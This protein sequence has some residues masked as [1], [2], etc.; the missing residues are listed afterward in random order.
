MCYYYP[1]NIIKQSRVPYYFMVENQGSS[2]F[3]DKL[4]PGLLNKHYKETLKTSAMR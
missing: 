1:L 2:T 3:R 4:E